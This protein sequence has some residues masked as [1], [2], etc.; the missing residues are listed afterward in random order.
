MRK[1]RSEVVGALLYRAGLKRV[2]PS[3]ASLLWMTATKLAAHPSMLEEISTPP[4]T[5]AAAAVKP[6]ATDVETGDAQHSHES[7]LR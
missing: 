7:R 4:E 1:K 5:A 6:A 3:S 2:E